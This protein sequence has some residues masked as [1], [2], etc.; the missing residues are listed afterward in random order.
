M[1]RASGISGMECWNGMKWWN[2]I[3]KQGF[4]NRACNSRVNKVGKNSRSGDQ[5]IKEWGLGDRGPE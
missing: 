2:G 3:T 1:Y 4:Q 5:L